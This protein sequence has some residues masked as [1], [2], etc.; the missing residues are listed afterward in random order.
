MS[1][2]PSAFLS[3]AALRETASQPSR[4]VAASFFSRRVSI[5][6]KRKMDGKVDEQLPNFLKNP[7]FFES[8]V[9]FP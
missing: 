8:T 6:E 2:A 9:L 5:I 4:A 3:L 1:F 7:P